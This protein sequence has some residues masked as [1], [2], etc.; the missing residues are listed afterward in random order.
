[1]G[2]GIAWTVIK[3]KRIHNIPQCNLVDMGVIAHC[4]SVHSRTS[5]DT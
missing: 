5:V 4:V 1:M 3:S 2:R